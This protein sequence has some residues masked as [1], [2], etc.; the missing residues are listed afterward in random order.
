MHATPDVERIENGEARGTW[1]QQM[2]KQMVHQNKLKEVGEGRLAN[3]YYHKSMMKSE[4]STSMTG[5][6]T[7]LDRE[8]S[9]VHGWLSTIDQG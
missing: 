7:R 2:C 9:F 6:V 1:T 8:V 5:S 3:S 4:Q